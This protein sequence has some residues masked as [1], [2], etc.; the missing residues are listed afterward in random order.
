M[1]TIWRLHGIDTALG[2]A[3]EHGTVFAGISASAACWFEAC[4]TDPLGALASRQDGVQILPG[5]FCPH[6]D[7]EE[8][9][10]EV[11]ADAITRRLLPPGIGLDNGVAVRY[12]NKTLVDVYSVADQRTIHQLGLHRL[13]LRALRIWLPRQPHHHQRGR[14]EWLCSFL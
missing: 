14:A 5:S 12:T 9:R 8:D 2:Q 4:L 3:Y 7:T 6:Y 13:S 1:L 11:F 10:A